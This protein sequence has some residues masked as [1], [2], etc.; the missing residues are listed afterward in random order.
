MDQNW[1]Q[2]DGENRRNDNPRQN[3]NFNWRQRNQQNNLNELPV[4]Q[5]QQPQIRNDNNRPSRKFHLGFK[6]IET[7]ISQDAENILLEIKRDQDA[8]ILLMLKELSGDYIVLLIKL[9][10][11]MCESS[12]NE[13]KCQLLLITLDEKFLQNVVNFVLNLPL[14]DLEDKKRN[15]FF[16][17]NS[18]EFFKNLFHFSIHTLNLLT[19]RSCDK[20]SKLVKA[21]EKTLPGLEEDGMIINEEVKEM[22]A[23]LQLK[24]AVVL[25]NMQKRSSAATNP[26]NGNEPVEDEADWEPPEN[27]R[28]IPV[29]P[30]EEELFREEK[31]FIRRNLIEGPYR[32]VNHYLDIQFRLLREDFVGPL[33]K[34]IQNYISNRENKIEN[35][36]IHQKV[37]FIQRYNNNKQV[38]TLLKFSFNKR[39]KFNE[40]SKRLIYGSLLCFTNSNFRSIFFGKVIDRD[41]KL[42]NDAMI[43]VDLLDGVEIEYLKDYTMIEC[44]IFFEPYYQVLNALQQYDENNFPLEN[45]LLYVD[46]RPAIPEYLA[47]D[48]FTI[49]INKK[50]F[51]AD[52]INH[53]PTAD[54]IKLNDSQYIAFNHALTRKLVVI[55]GPPGTGKTYLGLKIAETLLENKELWYDRGPMLVVCYTNHALDQFLE[56]IST[57]TQNIIRIGGQSRSEN[58][59]KFNIKNKRKFEDTDATYTRVFYDERNALNHCLTRIN[60]CLEHIKATENFDGIVKIENIVKL[61]AEIKGTF[62]EAVVKHDLSE[63]LFGTLDA[64]HLQIS[65][66]Q[67]LEEEKKEDD[68][69]S[70]MED[71]FIV[72]IDDFCLRI[73]SSDNPYTT[74]LNGITNQINNLIQTLENFSPEDLEWDFRRQVEYS[75]IQQNIQSL[76]HTFEYLSVCFKYQIFTIT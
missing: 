22:L 24:I 38:G 64:E 42:L 68:D 53:W 41:S 55:Q 56:G 75:K 18:N 33:R 8:F 54:E 71:E 28:Q 35:V 76:Q 17:D 73:G 63:W 67:P 19:T 36:R 7:L 45:Y 27:F 58:M 72:D 61:D 13:M 39:F 66:E 14:H 4:Q 43:V 3:N 59:K 37:Q 1:R 46:D 69:D 47:K 51:S 57:V 74:T 21:V 30:T 62:L 65:S 11:K 52:E 60:K 50:Y 48:N 40:N 23:N 25:E 31:P 26:N 6:K 2:N 44:S 10:A 9:F 5:P 49:K 34:A 32:N 70:S 12:Y 16:W 20:I 29:I 15:R